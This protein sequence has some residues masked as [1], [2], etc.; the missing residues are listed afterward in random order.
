MVTPLQGG[1]SDSE[2]LS[3][4]PMVTQLEPGLKPKLKT[5]AMPSLPPGLGP[6]PRS[7]RH[8]CLVAANPFSWRQGNKRCHGKREGAHSLLG[9]TRDII[10]PLKSRSSA[11]NTHL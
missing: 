3:N 7:L 4:L 1:E 9:Q 11:G 2:R 5:P 6:P 8:A 10:Y